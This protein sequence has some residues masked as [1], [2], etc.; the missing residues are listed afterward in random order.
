MRTTLALISATAFLAAA[1][2]AAHPGHGPATGP[3]KRLL[4]VFDA[5]GDGKISRAEFDAKRKA[6]IQAHFKKMD[7]DGDGHLTLEEFERARL[8]RGGRRFERLDANGDGVID[9]TELHRPWLRHHPA[10]LPL[11]RPGPVQPDEE[12]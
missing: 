4:D 8:A 3:A 9:A 12:A 5:N 2:T 7:A 11:H 1:V 6:R 10:A